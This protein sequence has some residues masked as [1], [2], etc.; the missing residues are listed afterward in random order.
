M[1][2]NNL[3]KPGWGMGG[4]ST[5]IEFC[6]PELRGRRDIYDQLVRELQA[7]GLLGQGQFVH[8]TMSGGGMLESRTTERG[9]AF[10]KYISSP[11]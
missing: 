1:Q 2:Q 8:V 7:E 3:N 4:V 6:F 10:I 9:K 5:V 11:P